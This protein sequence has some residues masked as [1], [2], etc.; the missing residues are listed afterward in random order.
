M[1][2]PLAISI[3]LATTAVAAA[4][5]DKA[6]AVAEQLKPAARAH[7]LTGNTAYQTGDFAKASVEFEAAYKKLRRDPRQF[8]AVLLDLT[9]PK[10]DGEDTLMALRMLA[11]NLPVVLTSGYSEQTV[12]QRSQ[13]PASRSTCCT[14]AP[15]WPP[16]AAPRR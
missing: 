2:R 4:D 16:T 15:P 9:M 14:A 8:E 5:E 10:L 1:I 6:Q 13:Q 7:F 11:P 3:V 12:A